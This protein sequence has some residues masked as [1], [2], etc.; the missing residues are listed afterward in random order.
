[1]EMFNFDEKQGRLEVK[2]TMYLE[3]DLDN[4]QLEELY[5]NLEIKVNNNLVSDVEI[6]VEK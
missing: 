2:L 3:M 6:E 5:K 4:E 1:M